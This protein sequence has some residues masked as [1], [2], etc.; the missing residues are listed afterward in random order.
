MP[1][2]LP[3]VCIPLLLPSRPPG[4]HA[5]LAEVLGLDEDKDSKDEE[6]TDPPSD[7]EE[8]EEEEVAARTAEVVAA[9]V[10]EVVESPPFPVEGAV[11][12]ARR[13]TIHRVGCK[14]G[15]WVTACGLRLLP[16]DWEELTEWPGVVWPLCG[17]PNCFE[18]N[19]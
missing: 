15:D 12:H 19:K 6:L 3:S 13:R 10:K 14:E 8:V 2:I 11:R 5:C 1:R 4:Q 16:I 18:V 9:T 7:F 17:R